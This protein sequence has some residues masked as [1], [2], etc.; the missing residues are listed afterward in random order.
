MRDEEQ[1]AE[2]NNPTIEPRLAS[3]LAVDG[4]LRADEHGR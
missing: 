3:R 4:V 1:Q 2:N